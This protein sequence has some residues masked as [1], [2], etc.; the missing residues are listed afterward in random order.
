MSKQIDQIFSKP[1]DIFAVPININELNRILRTLQGRLDVLETPSEAAS[2][3]VG[4]SGF[5][6]ATGTSPAGNYLWDTEDALT[7]TA[8]YSR[9]AS[10]A[11]VWFNL[12]GTYLIQVI[13]EATTDAISGDAQVRLRKTV[14]GA[15]TTVSRTSLTLATSVTAGVP[16]NGLIEVFS[17]GTTYITVAL[18]LGD[19]VLPDSTL[20][21]IKVL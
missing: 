11:Q 4:A 12:P 5:W 18:A 16:V 15:T 21:I 10:D 1:K 17:S 19:F 14:S 20:S 3:S 9:Q 7:D 13:A 6:T 2:G 8:V